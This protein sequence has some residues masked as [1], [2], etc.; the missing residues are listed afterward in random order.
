MGDVANAIGRMLKGSQKCQQA[1]KEHQI[2]GLNRN[3]KPEVDYT[4]RIQQPKSRQNAEKCSGSA[5][6][7]R[8]GIPGQPE[9]EKPG[10]DATDEV[11]LVEIPAP[12]FPFQILPGHPQGEH[13][14]ENMKKISMQKHIGSQLP[15]IE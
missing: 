14:E 8:G 3:Q 9:G 10:S 6:S 7:G 15:E 11:E 12:P 13:I 1:E 4:V 5:N 2:F